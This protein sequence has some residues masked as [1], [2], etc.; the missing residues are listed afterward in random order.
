MRY[1][2]TRPIE[3]AWRPQFR[4]WRFDSVHSEPQSKGLVG[5]DLTQL[6]MCHQFNRLTAEEMV[7]ADAA[8]I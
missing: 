7:I 4:K 8:A 6:I 2:R 5:A 1:R 3:F